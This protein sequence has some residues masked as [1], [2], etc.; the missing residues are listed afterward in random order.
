MSRIEALP[1]MSFGAHL[2][3]LRRR[4]FRS[5][6]AL[7]LTTSVAFAFHKELLAVATIPHRRAHAMFDPPLEV[8]IITGDYVAPVQALIKLSLL[9]GVLGASP[10]IGWQVWAF[11]GTGLYARERRWALAFGICS[12][13]LFLIG[14]AA[15]YFLLIPYTLYGLASMLP[16]DRVLPT[17]ELAGYLD[18]LMT[19][20]V[21]LGGVF[22]L[23]LAMAFLTRIG[24]VEPRS[25]GRWRKHGVVGNVV[26][27]AVLAPGDP[28]SLAAFAAPLLVL[29]EGGSLAARFCAPAP[30]AALGG[31]VQM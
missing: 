17:F 23:P 15:G 12:F 19:L 29:Y 31:I 8:T 22:Q 16:L 21:A 6:L 27:A 7:L 14:C 24:L 5:I 20:T 1:R 11:V 26:L 13:L 9:V 25:W 28:L 18:L 30:P 3:E 2:E 4:L 10:V